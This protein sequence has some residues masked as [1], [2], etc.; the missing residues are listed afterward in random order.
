MAHPLNRPIYNAEKGLI[1]EGYSILQPRVAVSLPSAGRSQFVKLFSGDPGIDPYT[2]TTSD[3]YQDVFHE[4]SFIGKGI[5]DVDAFEHAVGGKFPE[6]RILSHD[7]L[8]GSYALGAGQLTM[9]LFEFPLLATA[10]TRGGVIAGYAATGKSR[11]GCCPACPAW[12][13]GRCKIR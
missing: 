13:C 2:R 12:T 10:P 7:L 4:G 11:P 9:Q 6:N 8:E 3:V 5:Y 1:V